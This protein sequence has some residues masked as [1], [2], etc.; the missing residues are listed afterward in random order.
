MRFGL[1]L[2]LWVLNYSSAQDANC[3]F[4]EYVAAGKKNYIYSPNYSASYAPGVQCRWILTCPTGYNCRLDC[5]EIRLPQTTSCSGDRLLLSR[6]GDPQLNN[7][8]TYCGTGSLANVTST[9]QTI[10][11]GLIAAWNSAGGRFYCTVTPQV[12]RPPTPSCVCG[13]R[14][15]N[16][17]V[18]G[19]ETGINEFTMM[20]PL[21]DRRITQIKC[22]GV[23]LTR[24]HVMSAA[25]CVY[26]QNVNNFAVLVGEHDIT[27]GDTPAQAAYAISRFITHPNYNGNSYESDISIVLV[28]TDM[29]FSDLVGP[30]CLPFTQTSNSFAGSKVTVVGWGTTYFGGPTSNV[31]LKVD[32]DVLQ[33]STCRTSGAQVTDRQM[34]TFTRGKDSCQD[35][36]GGP[37][38]WTNPNNGALYVVG[39]VS[40]GQA[41]ASNTPS[42]N[43]RVTSYLDWIVANTVPQSSY[44]TK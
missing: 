38:L 4:Y 8:E 11:L 5:P 28:A 35:D 33:Q 21:V 16:R 12:A 2:L 25:H 17:I 1:V 32:L 42:I 31:P 36:S 41:C 27:T 24:R 19:Q 13:V 6:S 22:G 44:C 23:I 9:A 3:D 43:T 14:R 26:N 20:A 40:F 29:T 37:L 30:V 15:Q 39:I 7:A 34:C 10:S 18:G